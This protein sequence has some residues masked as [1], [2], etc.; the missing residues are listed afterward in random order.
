MAWRIGEYLDKSNVDLIVVGIDCNEGLKR[1][2]EYGPWPELGHG[3]C[4]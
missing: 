3:G 2:D 4:I 1:L